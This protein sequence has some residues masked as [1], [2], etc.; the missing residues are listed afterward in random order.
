MGIRATAYLQVEPEFFA[1]DSER[2]RAAKVVRLTQRPPLHNQ[3]GGT[4]LVK[5]TVDLP[6]AAFKPLQ[7]QAV[8]VVPEDLTLAR[9]L[10]EVEADEPT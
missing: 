9:S 6:E 10:I 7:P 3:L 1:Y 4:V 5:I 2:V 8:V